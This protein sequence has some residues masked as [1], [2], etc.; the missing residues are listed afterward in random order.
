MD[1]LA[2]LLAFVQKGGGAYQVAMVWLLYQVWRE[3]RWTN[4]NLRDSLEKIKR[5]VIVS[6][7]ETARIFEEA[8]LRADNAKT[9]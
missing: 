6:N 4:A 9:S 8:P 5:A 7:P 3:Q 1:G 2:E